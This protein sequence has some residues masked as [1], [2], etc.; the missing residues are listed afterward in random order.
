MYRYGVNV[1][2]ELRERAGLTQEL[3]ARLTGISPSAISRLENG[4]VS[5]TLETL[6]R[7]AGPAN[8][9]VVVMFRLKPEAISGDQPEQGSVR[10]PNRGYSVRMAEPRDVP[11]EPRRLDPKD[12]RWLDARLAEYR[13]LLAYLRDH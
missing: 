4:H 13:E 10:T 1:V 7:I 11:A 8:L 3:L 12:R 2:R 9:D 6:R 5:P